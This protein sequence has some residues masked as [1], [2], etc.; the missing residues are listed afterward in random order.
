[1]TH[2]KFTFPLTPATFCLSLFFIISFVTTDLMAQAPAGL[3]LSLAATVGYAPVVTHGNRDNAG[4]VLGIYGEL[5]YGKVIGRLQYTRPLL[6][7]FKKDENLNSGVSYHGALGYR[8]D[9]SQQV[10]VGLLASGG[11]TVI[12]YNNGFNGSSGDTFTNVSPQV[13]IIVAPA[14][15]ITDHFSIQLNLRYYKGFEAGD[16]GEASD[17]ADVSVGLRF[18]L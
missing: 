18:S 14:Y 12:Q 11:A 8:F 5:E 2:A 3:R 15:Q 6:S 16:R 1:M 4:S 7:T 13:G 10:F 17:L 9:L